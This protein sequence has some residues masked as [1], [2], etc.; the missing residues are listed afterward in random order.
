M[1][2]NADEPR[3]FALES[4]RPFGERVAWELDLALS[5]HEEREFDDGEHKTRPLE[6]VR[7]RDVFVLHSLYADARE[8]VNDKLCRFLFFLG[9]CRDAGAGRLTAV[10]PY[11]CYARKDRKTKSRDPVTTRYVAQIFE[12]VGVD[13]VVA[14]DVHNLAAYQN[15]FRGGTEHLEARVLFVEHFADLCADEDLAV[16]SPDVGGVKRAEAFREALASR[17]D[18]PVASG[19]ME[20]ERSRGVV[21]GD[22]FVGE[23]DGR[24]VILLD[25]MIATGT[26]MARAAEACREA[27]AGTCYA[28]STHG[29]FLEG[30][31]EVVRDSALDRVVVTDTVPP[32]RLPPELVSEKITLLDGAGLFAEAIRR[33]HE[34]GSVVELLKEE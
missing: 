16:V 22:T 30:A 31:E 27:G 34:G 28:A 12:A 29:L 33:L 9:A 4:S 15:A 1:T 18:R 13:R 8:S 19:F 21:S 26:T 17:L 32:F 5:S 24:T 3:L 23:V 20:K 10:V 7:D 6:S 2:A 14:M 11:L 25:D